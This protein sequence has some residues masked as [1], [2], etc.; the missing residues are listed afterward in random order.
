MKGWGPI[1]QASRD[2]EGLLRNHPLN[3]K[4]LPEHLHDGVHHGFGNRYTDP[5]LQLWHGT[6]A[7]HKAT[8]ASAGAAAA[9][10]HENNT[11]AVQAPQPKQR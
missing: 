9:D 7:F 6:N 4:I 1:P 8:I 11:R 2:A 10:I 5:A 3:M